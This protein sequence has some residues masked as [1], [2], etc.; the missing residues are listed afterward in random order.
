MSSPQSGVNTVVR[1]TP[2]NDLYFRK[3]GT[4]SSFSSEIQHLVVPA[5]PA[6]PT[7]TIDFAAEKTVENISEAVSYAGNSNFNSAVSG[8]NAPVTVI[9][10]Q[11]LYFR[12]A[13]TAASFM[14]LPVTLVA[15]ARPVVTS[16]LTSPT[17]ITPI[18]VSIE[19][20]SAVTGI[21]SSDL[22]VTNGSV[23]SLT[24]SYEAS[25]TPTA[26]G[27]VTVT[28][29]PN[30]ATEG[31]FASEAYSI[32]YS[33][34][35]G[36]SN[37]AKDG[38]K[39]YPTLVT[40]SLYLESKDCLGCGYRIYNVG[41]IPVVEGTIKNNK[42]EINIRTLATGSYYIVISLKDRSETLRFIKTDE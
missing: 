11:T 29:K 28:V 7:V 21:E 26:S 9:P 5:R 30:A 2:G 20:P 6:A 41:G 4:N 34:S 12:V 18:P 3:K 36:I 42:E 27:V 31:N 25:I 33:L 40:G 38:L 14:S 8:T 22:L 10:G 13:P 39:I 16:S 1:L 15:P 32:T 17:N 24:G 19:F 23:S 35:T 37:P